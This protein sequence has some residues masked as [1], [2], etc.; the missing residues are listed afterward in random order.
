M[1]GGMTPYCQSVTPP[2]TPTRLPPPRHPSTPS[3]SK[4]L[5]VRRVRQGVN[6]SPGLGRSCCRRSAE[7][8]GSRSMNGGMTPHCQSVTSIP[9]RSC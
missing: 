4:M 3:Q 2:P 8:G 1:S 9:A 6:P 7:A 5:K